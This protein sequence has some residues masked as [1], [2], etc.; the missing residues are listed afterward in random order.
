[1]KTYTTEQGD[2]WDG[3]V[4]KTLGDCSYTA[5][6]IRLNA[7]YSDVYLF[8]AGVK[9]TLPEAEPEEIIPA[10]PWKKAKT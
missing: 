6:L 5:A 2:M 1:M 8:D 10:L 9:L 3:I 7:A 4:Y